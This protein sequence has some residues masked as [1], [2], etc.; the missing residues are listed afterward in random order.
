[1]L[2]SVGMFLSG[3]EEAEEEE[4]EVVIH[5][6][7][8]PKVTDGAVVGQLV[9]GALRKSY[10]AQEEDYLLGYAMRLL[11]VQGSFPMSLPE[12]RETLQRRFPEFHPQLLQRRVI[13]VAAYHPDL[14][15]E[16]SFSAEKLIVVQAACTTRRIGH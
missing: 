13:W 8:A 5:L 12:L 9:S 2:R 16:W 11:L 14:A 1:M 6:P 4:T 15:L 10:D 3:E 7:K